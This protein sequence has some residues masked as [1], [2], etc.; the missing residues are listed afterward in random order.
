MFNL[1]TTYYICPNI[2]RQKELNECLINNSKNKH[3][4]KIYL[5]NEKIHELE[6]LENIDK[7]KQIVVDDDSKK[8]LK[9]KFAID[10]INENLKGEKCILANSDIYYDNTLK[11]LSDYDMNNVFIALSR[12]D[13]N[14][15]FNYE[16]SQDTWIFKSPLNIN[17]KKLDFCFGILGCDNTF[18][19]IAYKNKLKIINP[20]MTIKS[21][22]LH[23]SKYRTYST[24]DRIKGKYLAITPHKLNEECLI[25]INTKFMK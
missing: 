5:L 4:K 7:I 21:H 23:N 3:I 13:D 6:F 14:K 9:Y 2:N 12:Y 20:S 11:L 22:H 8:R 24:K 10:F 15:L 17:S 16:L 18:A 19:Y 1:V 25:S